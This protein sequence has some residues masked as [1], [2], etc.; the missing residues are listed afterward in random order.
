MID[1]QPR[2]CRRVSLRSIGDAKPTRPEPATSVIVATRAC[3]PVI[4]AG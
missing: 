3:V 4:P 2:R 1:N